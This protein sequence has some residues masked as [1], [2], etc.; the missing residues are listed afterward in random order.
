MDTE[1][2]KNAIAA[3]DVAAVSVLQCARRLAPGVR[4]SA[5]VVPSRALGRLAALGV[6]QEPPPS[7]TTLAWNNESK[8]EILLPYSYRCLLYT[9]RCV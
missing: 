4:Y 3:G 7:A 9:S 1:A 6:P 8:E 5:F 2:I